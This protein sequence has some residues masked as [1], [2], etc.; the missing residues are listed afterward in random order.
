MRSRKCGMSSLQE[1]EKSIVQ[2]GQSKNLLERSIG[3]CE[4][5]IFINIFSGLEVTNILGTYTFLSSN[6]K[7]EYG[8]IIGYYVVDRIDRANCF[9]NDYC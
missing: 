1:T 9:C 4:N 3:D 6:Q 7:N 5:C 2:C 8:K